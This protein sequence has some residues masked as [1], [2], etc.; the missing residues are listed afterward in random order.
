MGRKL[1]SPNYSQEKQLQEF[2]EARKD[3]EK[4]NIKVFVEPEKHSALWLYSQVMEALDGGS[5]LQKKIYKF[6]DKELLVLITN[7]GGKV[8]VRL[9]KN[10]KG[11]LTMHW[12]LLKHSAR[13]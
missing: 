10:M 8:H 3:L 2:E 5:V 9:A 12:G 11:P 4:G 7:P 1:A 13:E 6:G